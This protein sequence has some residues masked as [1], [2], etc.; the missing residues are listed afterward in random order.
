MTG[1]HLLTCYSFWM[2]LLVNLFS[3]EKVVSTT[4]TVGDEEEWNT[5]VNY[6]SWSQKYNFSVGD[7]LAFNYVKGQHNVVE[8][9]EET[10]RSCDA[11]SGVLATY[12]SGMDQVKLTQAGNYWFIC[13]ISG[14]CLGGMK[15]GI[16]VREGN[17]T[18]AS[19]STPPPPTA[20]GVHTPAKARAWAFLAAAL[21]I[22]LWV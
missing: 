6:L 20:N 15:F 18:K 14:H 5:G 12:N 16:V 10:Y 7:V 11:S 1:I 3:A 2:I 8:V 13:N 4:Y 17:A 21:G 19:V 9:V 22:L